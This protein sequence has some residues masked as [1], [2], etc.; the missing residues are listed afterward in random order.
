MDQG[1]RICISIVHTMIEISFPTAIMFLMVSQ[2]KMVSFVDSPVFVLYFLF[3][4]LSIL[5][6]DF[7]VSIFAG[8]LCRTSIRISNL[9]WIPLR[10]IRK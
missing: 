2:L 1:R 10:W 5:H 6:L 3:I 9:L 4:I 8:C 7:R